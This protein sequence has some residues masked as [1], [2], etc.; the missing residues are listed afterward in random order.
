MLV[1]QASNTD[2]VL[3]W[4]FANYPQ[5]EVS[6]DFLQYTITLVDAN[7]LTVHVVL[8]VPVNHLIATL[9]RVPGTEVH[10]SGCAEIMIV[11]VAS[12]VVVERRWASQEPW[13]WCL[14][15]FSLHV[16]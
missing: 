10:C 3:S 12:M 7:T 14:G 6:C 13:C 2:T 11:V 4:C 8:S 5:T 16:G 15:V 9:K 1:P